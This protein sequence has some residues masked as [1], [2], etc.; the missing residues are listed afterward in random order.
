FRHA[1]GSHSA[2]RCCTQPAAIENGERN[3]RLWPQERDRG[4]RFVTMTIDPKSIR[5]LAG[6]L[7]RPRQDIES[8]FVAV[9][10]RLTEGA[11]LLNTLSKLFE[12]LPEALG[13]AEVEEATTRLG[14]VAVRAEE[15]AATF[16]QEKADLARLVDV[17]A[18]ANSPIADLKRAVKMMGIVSV[19]ARVTAAGIV[20]DS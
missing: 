10:A 18:A 17:V 5:H 9:G 8:A 16:A 19:N 13:G 7:A 11:A 6:E 2:R 12:A 4:R 3:H 20:G 1:Q 14:A 15:L